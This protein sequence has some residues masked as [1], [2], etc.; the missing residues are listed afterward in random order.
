MI[1]SRTPFRIS[2][3]GGGTDYP[4]WYKKHGG[5]VLATTIDKFL[6]LTSRYL[7]PFFE[8]RIRIVYGKVETCQTREQIA[9]PVVREV[10]RYLDIR[11]GV[12][13]HYDA[14]LPGR[15]GMGSSS[16]FTV[17][18]LHA[19]HS[20]SG[21]MV[22][23]QQ[24]ANDAIHIEQ[25]VL[26]ETVGSQDQ[27][28]AAFGGLN[29]VSFL[30]NGEFSVRP[31]ILPQS[32]MAELNS[33]LMLLY[34]GIKRTAANVAESYIQDL[35]SKGRQ[36]RMTREMVEE[37]LGILNGGH[38][39]EDFGKLLHEA[40][41]LKRSLGG[42]VSNPEVDEIYEQARGLGALGGKVVGA[43]GGG[44]MLLFAPPDQQQ[45]IR[46]QLRGLIH[47]PF[48]F[49]FG[50]SQIIFYDPGQDYAAEDTARLEHGIQPFRELLDTP[51]WETVS[52]AAK[53]AAT[54]K[55]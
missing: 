28:L 48:R 34:T 9:H 1:I 37:G 10:L 11:R 22:A 43:G 35:D 13:I 23:K 2:F 30:A 20:L 19:L 32:R 41:L 5:A 27:V 3:F 26:H 17:S 39:I 46:D 40:W 53:A 24:L 52:P 31:V 49:E 6:Y 44:F 33:H 47:V 42:L 12:E 16:V 45:R 50:G 51:T 4:A 36:L 38:P 8:H 14:D 54:S 25:T 55:R 21:Q 18:L 15:S 29:H 7:P